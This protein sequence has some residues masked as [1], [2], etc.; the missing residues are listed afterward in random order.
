LFV[1]RPSIGPGLQLGRPRLPDRRPYGQESGDP[2]GVVVEVQDRVIATPRFGGWVIVWT[3]GML[4]GL[5]TYL[6]VGW[7]V[8]GHLGGN[9][10]IA[11]VTVAGGHV[12]A[13]VRGGKVSV[14]ASADHLHVVNL[15]RTVTVPWADIREAGSTIAINRGSLPKIRLKNGRSVTV[16]ALA[17]ERRILRSDVVEWVDEAKRR[18][19]SKEVHHILDQF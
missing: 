5:A 12:L 13:T 2:M 15:Y 4:A 1:A 18:I 19:S 10:I 8:S 17:G 14:V 3:H 9:G 11:L 16:L 6:A 7:L